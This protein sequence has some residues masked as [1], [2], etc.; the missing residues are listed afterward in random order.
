MKNIGL[1][2]AIVIGCLVIGYVAAPLLR[3]LYVNGGD[4]VAPYQLNDHATEFGEL[5]VSITGFGQ[6][7]AGVEVELGTPGSRKAVVTTD[8]TGT[9]TFTN[10]P[11]GVWTVFFDPYTFPKA[12]PQTSANIRKQ[13]TITQGMT[14]TTTIDL[15]QGQ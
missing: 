4:R 2:I 1:G 6:P 15:G 10:V 11:I 5:Q 8:D 14:V 12:Y 9:A 13:V 3:G 7:I